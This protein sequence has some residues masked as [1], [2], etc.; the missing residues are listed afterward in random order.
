[1]RAATKK[2]D[3]SKSPELVERE[4]AGKAKFNSYC[5]AK[6]GNQAILAR[7][8]GLSQTTIS[9]ISTGPTAITL[10]SAIRFEVATKGDLR[11]D[12]LCP[13]CDGLIEQFLQ[14]RAAKAG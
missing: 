10:E 5:R 1:M 8:T 13:S 2:G 14:L 12:D 11:A 3:G 6:Q 9:G 7:D 4:R